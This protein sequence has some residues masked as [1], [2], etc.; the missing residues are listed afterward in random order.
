MRDFS[1]LQTPEEVRPNL[2]LDEHDRLGPDGGKGT[3]DKC[4]PVDREINSAHLGGEF[5]SQL[6]HRGGGRGGDDELEVRQPGLE[7]LDQLDADIR[8]TDADC[9]QPKNVPVADGLL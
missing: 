4:P 5:F 3:P 1:A 8:L 9:V 7:H 6:T 2:R